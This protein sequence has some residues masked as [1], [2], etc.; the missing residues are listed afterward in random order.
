MLIQTSAAA[1]NSAQ[2]QGAE[3]E[4]SKKY[5]AGHNKQHA[6]QKNTALLDAETEELHVEHVQLSLGKVIQQARQA[7]EWTQKELGAHV[8]EKVEVI[9]EYESAKAIPNTNILAKMERALGV[10]LRGKNI[11]QPLAA[12]LPKK[13]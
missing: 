7:K 3:I 2:R 5:M 6:V 4:T 9:K 1:I 11:G 13:K 10:K 8:N 12:P